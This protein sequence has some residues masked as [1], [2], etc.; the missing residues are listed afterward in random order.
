MLG[1]KSK[2]SLARSKRFPRQPSWWRLRFKQLLVA[3]SC[4]MIDHATTDGNNPA[5]LAIG[6]RDLRRAVRIHD[7]DQAAFAAVPEPETQQASKAGG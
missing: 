3:D 4:R 1:S 5:G 7:N 2:K 6:L